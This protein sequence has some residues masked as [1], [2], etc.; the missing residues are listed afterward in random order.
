MRIKSTILTPDER[1]STVPNDTAKTPLIM[2]VCGTLDS[3]CAIGD[4]ATVV[5][6]MGRVEK[7][8]LEEANPSSNV[9]Y[10]NFIPEILQIGTQAREI[11]FGGGK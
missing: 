7:G 11:L 5:T 2:W 4:V 10:G 6:K 3:D 1:A 9:D 8:E